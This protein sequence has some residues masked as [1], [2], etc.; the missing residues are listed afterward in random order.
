M[1]AVTVHQLGDLDSIAVEDRPTP[2]AG[3]HDVVISIKAAPVNYVDIVTMRGEYQF[4]PVLPYVPGKGPAGV[5]SAV[6]SSVADMTIGDRVL[7]MAEYGG[8]AEAVAV[9][10]Q[11]VFRLPDSISFEQAAAMSVAYDTAWIALRDRARIAPGDSVLVLGATGAVGQAALQLARVMGASLLLA[12]VSGSNRVVA[13]ADGVV[14]TSGTNPRD[15]IREQ[16]RACTGGVGVDIVVDMLG[17]D[18]FDGAVRSLAWRGRL[19]V[20]GFAS[21]RIPAVKVNYLLLKNIEISGMQVS[22]YR[23]RTPVLMRECFQEIF[24]CVENQQITL[25]PAQVMPLSDWRRAIDQVASRAA[26]RRLLLRP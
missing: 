21:G 11:S 23:R 16:V 22:D 12:G 10:R 6:G 24:H 19:V 26:D 5:V 8:Y 4:V 3:P 15:S 1:R 9:E 7:A 20:V 13:N 25:S 18:A 2:T 17:G 14:D